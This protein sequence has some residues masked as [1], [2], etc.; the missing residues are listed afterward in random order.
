MAKK[1]WDKPIDKN[2]PWD[3]NESTDN[4][5]VRGRRVEEFIKETFDEKFGVLEYDEANNRYLVFADQSTR[6]AYLEDPTQ[7]HLL[8]GAF[9]APFNYTAEITLT[10]PTYNAVFLGSTGN[11]ID[12]TFDVKNKQGASTG[13]NVNVTYTFI[14]NAN[15]K[16]INETRRYGEAV[17]F[18][19]DEYIETGTNTIIIGITGQST[20]AATTVAL[21]YQVV[22]LQLRDEL[23]ISKVY[24]L[25][26]GNVVADV[27]FSVSGYGQKTVEW[28]L[29]GEQLPFVKSEDEIVDVSS[30]RTKY[31]TLSN[32]SSGIHTLQFRA[33]TLINGDKFYTDTLYRE[34]IIH[35][36]DVDDNALAIATS[37]PTHHGIVKEDNPLSFYGA[38]Q[39]LPYDIRFAT[40]K[41][42]NVDIYLGNDLLSTITTS[43][44][45]ESGY[46]VVS[47]KAGTLALRF[48][49]GNAE[50]E[51]PL[52]IANTSLNVEE[53]TTSLSFDFTARGRS[54]SSID[55][56]V[57]S[58][59]EY[60]G[61]FSGFNW[62]ASSGWVNNALLIN[63]G[64]SFEVDITP[65][66]VV[67]TIAG[68][69]L[70]FEFATRNVENDDAIICNLQT[71]GVGLLITAS[72]AM[73]KSA[74][75]EIVETRFKAGDVNRISFVI[76]KKSGVTYKGL[77]F[78]Y[79]NGILSGA[80]NYGS[81]DNFTSGAKLSFAGTDDAQVE[82]RAMRFYDIALS[83]ENIINNY[84]LYRDS[85]AEM[86]EVYYR[87]DIY[88]NGTTTF[89]PD[90]AQ[91]RLPV[92]I[93]TGDIPTLEG[94]T[95]TSTQITVDV[96]YVNEQNPSYSFTMKNAAMRIQGTS[97]LAYPRKNFRI[98]TTKVDNTIVY[99]AEGKVIEDKLYS[100]KDGAQPVDCWC[101]K[102]DYAE[103]SGTHNT[104]I[105]RIW[106]EAM[107]N[108]QIQH[109]NVLGEEVNGYALRTKAQEA[110]LE[111]GY[112][113]DV[114]TTIDGFPILLFYKRN[115]ND[116][117]LIF[118]GKYNFNNDKSTPSV[119]GFENIPNFD[120]SAVQCWETK[121]NGH[122]LGLF[123]DVSGFDANWAEAYESRYPD[124]SSP[125]T[126]YLKAFSVWVNGVSQEN[127]ITEKW[128][129]LDVYK[130]AAYYV[131]LMRFGAVDQVV[132]NGFITSEDG[133]HF[134][135]INYD[136]D[137]V[138][139]LIN[140][141][142][143][144][145][146]PEINRQTIGS[147]GEY[148]YA[149]HDSV[150][151]NLLE[152]DGEFMDIVSIV[153]NALYS[154]GLRY[155][156]SINIFNNEQASK[157]VERVYNQDAEYKYLLPFANAGTN[158]LFMLQGSRSSHRSWWLSK[159]FSLYDSLFVS[160]NYRDRNISFK[161]LN[162]TQPGLQFSIEAGTDM[163]Y[164]YGVNNG[165]REVGVAMDK[166]DS[167]TF[168]T[169]DTLN[170]GDVVKVFAA[171]NIQS[172]DLSALATRLAV[173]DCSASYD[174]T[175]GSKLKNLIL[176]GSNVTNTELGAISGIN[177]LKALQILNMEGF[178]GITSLD[179]TQQ[180]DF[181]RLYAIGSSISSVDFA[182]GA[183]VEHLELPS[184]ML[185]LNLQ[186]LPFLDVN[187]LVL[188]D[189][190][191][192]HSIRIEGCPNLSNDFSLISTWADAKT[193]PD[194]QCSLVM[195]NVLWDGVTPDGF[196]PILNIKVNGGT[197]NLKGRITMP[198]ASLEV[199]QTIESI[200]GEEVFNKDNDLYIKVPSTLYMDTPVASINEGE[201]ATFVATVY[202]AID[203]TVKYSL[204]NS[205]TGASIDENT[206]VLTTT[207]NGLATS[208]L[209]VKA[210]FTPAD[211]SDVLTATA[212][213]SVVKR[214]Y[215]SSSSVTIN[216]SANPLEVPNTYTWTTTTANVNGNMI[217][218]W[219][220][221]GDVT[222][223]AQIFSQDVDKCVLIA[224]DTPM[225]LL[226][227]TLTLTLKKAVNGATVATATK[228]L[229]AMMEGIIITSATNQGIQAA[230]YNAGLV[231]NEKYT[232]K[233]EAE[234]ITADQ[235]QP[236]TS[237]N[238]SI[239]YA[240]RN[241]IKS[242]E[243]FKYFTGV[244]QI[245]PYTFSTLTLYGDITIPEGV[246]VV[247]SNAF[248]QTAF[249]G[250]VHIP[251]TIT[252]LES[253]AFPYTQ[254]SNFGG[255][256]IYDLEKFCQIDAGSASSFPTYQAQ[257]GVN[258]D[259]NKGWIYLGSEK[260]TDLI[261]P[262]TITNIPPYFFAYWHSIESV[263]IPD[264]IT[265]LSANA[266]RL[267]ENLKKILGAKN[268]VSM[269]NY[270]VPFAYC[271]SL[272]YVSPEA[273]IVVCRF[274]TE[275]TRVLYYGSSN[276][277]TS[278]W[279]H[280]S[281]SKRFTCR[282]GA[283][284]DDMSTTKTITLSPSSYVQD[285]SEILKVGY[286]TLNIT[287][288]KNE[289]EFRVDYIDI[290]SGELVS[291]TVAGT[292]AH[293]LPIKP[294][295]TITVTP[296]TEYDGLMGQSSTTTAQATNSITANYI[297]RVDIYI[298]HIDGMLYTTDQWVS[299]GYTNNQANGVALVSASTSFVIAKK[300]AKSLTIKWGGYNKTIT[301][302]VTSTSSA[303]AVLDFDGEG[304]TTKIITQLAGYTDSGGV[305]GAPPAEAC[306]A[307]V[308]PNG[309]T[310]YMGAL[311]QWQAAYNNKTAVNSA[312]SLIGGTAIQTSYYWSSTQASATNAWS[313][314]WNYGTL[315]YNAKNG[316][317]RVRAFA[318]L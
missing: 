283:Y 186:Q 87:N 318:S 166:G 78:I 30:E 224:I 213:I 108:A 157:W 96:S 33:Y 101:L 276:S 206:G 20:L 315:D 301:D 173:L 317:C 126:S 39:Y 123:T 112:P 50:R 181:R 214:V 73:L 63:S 35:N 280:T 3:G 77:A 207:E 290:N 265:S 103:S 275:Q 5:P 263:F 89:S 2:T 72:R 21:T 162:N 16:V 230:L 240:Q 203:G 68:K 149:G 97:S 190:T 211:G 114:R 269:P 198:T 244:T 266:F 179:L 56:D 286:L 143:L 298:Q 65:L 303:T 109:K 225:G 216:G 28:F 144:R 115:A 117:N 228:S 137:T 140:T 131:Y 29:D 124:T 19:V 270:E 98:Y 226:D 220:L 250:K 85:L 246:T 90:K 222:S 4:L 258:E 45:R 102:A 122:P 248:Y 307:Y 199:I 110:A 172:L 239:F 229:Q 235:L 256:V 243:E 113:Y 167:H 107:Y 188:E 208:T 106:N 174:P 32:L 175:L 304:N 95:S 8:L 234:V 196:M 104:G 80:V 79:V 253:N 261:I 210:T 191:N 48:T 184:S 227:G 185:A 312:M 70:E 178:K 136:N 146:N 287:S 83:S 22:D 223:V 46:S 182:N 241:A 155:D 59:G 152:A 66:S 10:S 41:S 31:I 148:V 18:N 142:E 100:F 145:L 84:I 88:E 159:R 302:I 25:T 170:L 118:L 119:F 316:S 308:F 9:D 51:I 71:E 165:I 295:T 120:N 264:S 23:D 125:D 153:D 11:Y 67:A 47:N 233:A 128:A 309:K 156:T 138:N 278:I 147:D 202:P 281:G 49:I 294:S 289:S 215:P 257:Y 299:G 255:M 76:N 187:N 193:M 54:N 177:T 314:H 57:W 168:T 305:V 192:I 279:S 58:Y 300:D 34:L 218:E 86:M 52:V 282:S 164:G 310:G 205:R 37:L 130:V 40:R 237:S 94:A 232:L 15:K 200:Y 141:G 154:A 27:F 268:I 24:N 158:N 267:C 277:I 151:W 92:M 129:H 176:G 252:T 260:I 195:D 194:A 291:A 7:T 36:G 245:K 53:I 292:G 12:F 242:F 44:G 55:K 311:G 201:S 135:Y 251:T 273:S 105:A 60:T 288:N 189:S 259:E 249:Y 221:T 38:E 64:A 204:T 75:G 133:E 93:V 43:S 262:S 127:F 121:D 217:A 111:A 313:L 306:A 132:K 285:M 13:E 26:N 160:G 6:D 293:I 82:L 274:S 254:N 212:S 169:T 271:E 197:L 231:A 296:I 91:H 17:H 163:N 247:K 219:S 150:L 236:G 69:T 1:V 62:N 238:T 209:N 284:F 74:G 116:T 180:T 161:C 171:A 134:F 14:R 81:A 297:E 139:G 183:P 99:D 61:T 42:V 272:Q